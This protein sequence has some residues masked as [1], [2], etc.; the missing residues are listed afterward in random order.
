MIW[1]N[2]DNT[3]FWAQNGRGQSGSLVYKRPNMSELRMLAYLAHR[4]GSSKCNCK[5]IKLFICAGLRNCVQ[6][7]TFYKQFI[8]IVHTLQSG[9]L[10]HRCSKSWFY[11]CSLDRLND[12]ISQL[13]HRLHCDYLSIMHRYYSYRCC[14]T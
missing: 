4:N 10:H 5:V 12:T 9:L 11:Y 8:Y 7:Q 6:S 14:R 1:E 3:V 13:F 2:L